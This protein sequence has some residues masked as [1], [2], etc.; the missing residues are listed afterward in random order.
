V[1]PPD[2]G[3]FLGESR[4]M[5]PAVCRFISE[6]IYEGRLESD[7][8]CAR[9]KIAQSPGI[10]AFVTKESG[11]LFSSIQHDANVQQSDEEVERVKAIYDEMRGRFY[12]PKD[13]SVRPL[14]LNDSF[15]RPLQCSGPRPAEGFTE[16]SADRECRL[17]PRAGGSGLHSFPLLQLWRIR[18]PL[19]VL[20]CSFVLINNQFAHL[21]L[22]PLIYPA[23][24]GDCGA[25]R[26]R[27]NPQ[28][29]GTGRDVQN[30]DSTLLRID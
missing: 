9:Q 3:L 2:V 20:D 24:G 22:V 14:G 23:R 1:V 25:V 10:N 17:V 6:S 19:F 30:H 8:A 7:A 27:D 21:F 11:I 18:C 28:E 16:W 4:R 29:L 12:T 5:H 26:Q 13:L 15:Y